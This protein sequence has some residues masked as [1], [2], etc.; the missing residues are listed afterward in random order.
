MSTMII[1]EAGE[2]EANRC[3]RL[4]LFAICEVDVVLEATDTHSRLRHRSRLRPRNFD[5]GNPFQ[6]KRVQP[7]ASDNPSIFVSHYEHDITGFLHRKHHHRIECQHPT[8][9]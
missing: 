7:Y 4:V 1:D 9:Q 5:E 8:A 2:R 3:C 6:L